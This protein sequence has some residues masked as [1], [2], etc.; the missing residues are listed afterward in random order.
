MHRVLI[1]SCMLT[2][3]SAI[4]DV[5]LFS[6]KDEID[7]D[8]VAASNAV[9]KNLNAA[10]KLPPSYYAGFR[11]MIDD[12][13]YY[14]AATEF[15]AKSRP[16][17]VCTPSGDV[18]AYRC[19]EGQ[20][21]VHG[22]HLL[23]F[24]AQGKL[25]GFHTVNIQE[26]HPYFCNAIPAIGVADKSKNELLVTMQYFFIDGRG[27]KKISDVGS[28]WTRMTSL[29]R[30]KANDGKIEIE[31]DDSCLGNPNQLDTLGKAR[32]QVQRCVASKK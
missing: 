27:A 31:Q 21:L 32:K 8:F 1:I 11:L 14:I 5:Q 2:A 30:I 23:F 22:C 16:D 28:G 7:V 10:P 4:A 19:K 29:F 20:R 3:F 25:V 24:D 13:R 26:K 6:P 15:M 9:I 12:V 18:L 17:E